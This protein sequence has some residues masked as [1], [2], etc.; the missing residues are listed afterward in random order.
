[1]TTLAK[2]FRPSIWLLPPMAC[3][4]LALLLLPKIFVMA[5]AVSVVALALLV[6]AAAL[7]LDGRVETFVVAWVLLFPLGPYFLTYPRE[8]KVIFTLNRAL[9]GS[10]IVAMLV[11]HSHRDRFLPAPLRKAGI[12]WGLFLMA[13]L[14]SL[15]N[16][17][18]PLG[19]LKWS[20]DTFVLPGLL[21]YYVIR[22]FPVRRWLPTLHALACLMVFYCAAIGAVEMWTGQDLLPLAGGTVILEETGQ[23]LRVNGPFAGNHEF[24][25]VG[26][27]ALC[28][29]VFARR[30]FQRP[31]KGWTL[32]LHRVGI[33][34]ALTMAVM[35]MF[36]S[37]TITLALLLVVEVYWSKKAGARFAAAMV[38]VLLLTGLVAL[39]QAVPTLF[40]ARVSDTSDLYSR[41]AQQKQ[42][43]E[44][45]SQHPVNGVG[46]GKYN[47]VASGLATAYFHGAYS[48]GWAHN[49]LGAIVAETGLMG[50][51]PYVLAQVF[52]FQAFW[53]LRKRSHP[54]ITLA[55]SFFLYLFLTYWINGLLL[56]SGYDS[57]V[58][59]WY[60]F[61]IAVLYKFA[62]TAE[63][64][65]HTVSNRLPSWRRG[66]K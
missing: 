36:R 31:V 57:Y 30:A 43:L 29:L 10:L 48:V 45:F 60:F 13:T 28:F 44:M 11:G 58:N 59:L 49:N 33:S 9:V 54:D 55:T 65:G 64:H 20:I 63:S 39:R 3:A 35:P 5:G 7:T 34:C 32:L 15:R 27:M 4:V 50:F 38:L 19:M 24:G 22:Y 47:E 18:N 16:V 51:I 8:Q 21:A 23:L 40:E 66:Y 26:L 14:F 56:T 6:F 62:V 52:L 61:L 42:T 2:T 46:M 25:L 1:M 17:D 37:I 53:T 41:I 12:V